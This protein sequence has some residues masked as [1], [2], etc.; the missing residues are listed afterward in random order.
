MTDASALSP[1]TVPLTWTTEAGSAV[2]APDRDRLLALAEEFESLLLLQVMRQ[3]RQ[4]ITS[5]GDED[6]DNAVGV[7][8][9]AM[10]DTI[11]GELARY[12]SRAGGFGLS[13]FLER[14]LSR[15]QDQ[16]SIPAE[17]PVPTALGLSRPVDVLPTSPSSAP[18]LSDR[19]AFEGGEGQRAEPRLAYAGTVTSAFGWRP[20]PMIR[21]PRFHGGVD[22]RA[23][24]GQEVPAAGDGRVVIAGEQGSYGLTVVLEHSGGLRTRYAHLS[25]IAVRDGD[26][27]A[28]GRT[29]GRAGQ[30]GRARGP[31]VHLELTRDGQR[32]DPTPV[33]RVAEFKKMGIVAD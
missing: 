16:P 6:E 14:A 3:I 5:L 19:D 11:D 30:S 7:D 12:L 22:I 27:V 17:A 13:G 10:T 1:I 4:T 2:G 15:Q 25:S 31:H 32:L 26:S 21:A 28:A 8:L 20:D 24:Y 18:S 29:V 33:V 23:A 9:D